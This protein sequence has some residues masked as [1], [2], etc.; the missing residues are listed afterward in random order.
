MFNGT[1]KIT[2]HEKDNYKPFGVNYGLLFS[3][4]VENEAVALGLPG[5]N[6]NLY[7]V[8]DVFQDQKQWRKE[9]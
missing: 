4:Q 2:N 5:D 7:A 8:L 6:L 9:N 3:F 1:I